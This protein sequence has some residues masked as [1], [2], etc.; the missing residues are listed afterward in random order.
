MKKTVL[1]TTLLA[2]PLAL[3]ACD[4]STE[5]PKADAAADTMGDMA[6]PAE[7]KMAKGSG[8]VAAIDAAAGKITLNHGPIA[9]L[10]WPAMKM[11]FGVKPSELEGI[12]VGDTVSFEMKWDGKTGEI[13]NITRADR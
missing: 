1:M 10:E 9:E 5:A 11:G 6:M 8:T 7:A 3:S 12:V 13:T 4:K 2:L